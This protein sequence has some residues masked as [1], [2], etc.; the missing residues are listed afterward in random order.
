MS[1]GIVEAIRIT[2]T[3]D[4]LPEPVE[5]VHARAGAGLEGEYHDDLTL[6][7]AEVIE[8]DTEIPIRHAESRRNVLTRG[9]DLNALVGRRFRVGTVE[10]IGVELAEPCRRLERLNG[11]QRLL[12]HLAHRAGL[13]ADV[14]S[15]GEI[16]VGD[17]VV[18]L[19]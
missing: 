12:R 11:E 8:D 15:D 17:E 4:A 9:I 6:I 7:A 2:D 1:E 16:A 18:E 3:P 5:R 19:G 13:R 14:V 10:C